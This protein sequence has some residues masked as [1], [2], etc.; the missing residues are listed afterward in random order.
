MRS[1]AKNEV[2]EAEA[3]WAE[4]DLITRNGEMKIRRDG[5]KTEDG[6]THRKQDK[7]NL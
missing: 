6:N 1:N 2:D 3:G 4:M 5:K 7:P